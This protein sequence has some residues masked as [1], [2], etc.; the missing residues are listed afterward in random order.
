MQL[1]DVNGLTKSFG[2]KTVVDHVDLIVGRGDVVGFL[3]PNGAGKS[4]TM[5]M[6]VGFLEPDEGSASV[7]GFDVQSDPISA[8][9]RIGYLP[10]G[11]PAYGDMI[12]GDFLTF[13]G[14]LRRLGGRLLDNRLADMAEKINLADVWGEKVE[15]LSKGF[16]RR[17]GIAQALIHDPDVLILDE[18]TDGLDPIQKH[19]MRALIQAISA[20]K[21][22]VVST[23]ILEEVEAVCGRVVIIAR[24]RVLADDAPEILTEKATTAGAITVRLPTVGPDDATRM[25]K[26]VSR[27][28]EIRV[29]DNHNGA[30]RVLLVPGADLVGPAELATRLNEAGIRFD[31][32][33]T[34]RPS[35]EDVFR[36]IT[37][38]GSADAS[39]QS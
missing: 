7:C 2:G 9:L 28:G 21:A 4:T 8:R 12:V 19:E 25:I 32:I 11:A 29:L 14:K 1:I 22:I 36:E 35:L 13:V 37:L 10:E 23:H 33:G 38:D 5:K 26:S 30:A 16:K 20:E 24:G 17:V 18:P 27:S 34:Y 31:E 3:G 6:I 15:N 39:G